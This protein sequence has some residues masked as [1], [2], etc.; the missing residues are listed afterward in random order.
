MFENTFYLYK[1]VIT[2]QFHLY[3][4]AKLCLILFKSL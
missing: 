4:V 2:N 1:K 3:I